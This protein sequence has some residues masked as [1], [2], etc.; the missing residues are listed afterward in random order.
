MT[1]P[2][3]AYKMDSSAQNTAGGDRKVQ[4]SFVDANARRDNVGLVTVLVL[5]RRENAIRTCVGR[6]GLVRIPRMLQRRVS[7]V[8]SDVGMIIL[9]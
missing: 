3:P 2:A 7:R 4:I 9:V 5:R 6:A 1:K 8:D